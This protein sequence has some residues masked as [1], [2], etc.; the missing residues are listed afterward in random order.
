VFDRAAYMVPGSDLEAR[1][2][3]ELEARRL[4]RFFVV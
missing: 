1:I 4:E 2:A 3:E